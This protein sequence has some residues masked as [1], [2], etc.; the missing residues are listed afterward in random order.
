MYVSSQQLSLYQPVYLFLTP[1]S[2]LTRFYH[3]IM[4][5]LDVRI[6]A[7]NACQWHDYNSLN[8]RHKRSDRFSRR[9]QR[10]PIF[11]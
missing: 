1:W 11:V 8:A 9:Q 5:H 10:Q 4:F 2:F 7:T 3:E 6:V